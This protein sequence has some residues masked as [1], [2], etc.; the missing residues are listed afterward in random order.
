MN[1]GYNKNKK[2][3][4]NYKKHILKYTNTTKNNK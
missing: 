1:N 2:K 3:K 4:H